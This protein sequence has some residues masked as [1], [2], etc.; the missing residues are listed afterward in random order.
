MSDYKEV[1]MNIPITDK[2]TLMYALEA[3][4]KGAVPE[5]T[6]HTSAEER[7]IIERE[8]ANDKTV[9]ENGIM[10]NRWGH[11]TPADIVARQGQLPGEL[12]GFGDVGFVLGSDG[13]YRFKGCSQEDSEKYMGGGFF[14]KQ[15][16]FTQ[17]VEDAY[18]MIATIRQINE[19]LPGSQLGEVKQVGQGRAATFES[20][21]SI[22]TDDLARSGIRIVT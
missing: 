11:P 7:A 15:K 17:H 12:R 8:L 2:D 10:K 13:K 5:I 1:E 18:A 19:N 22:S 4:L 21:F 16:V 9:T 6:E 3:V 20:K 14:E